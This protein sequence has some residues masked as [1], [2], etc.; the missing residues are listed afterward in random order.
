MH[1]TKYDITT[2]VSPSTMPKY[3]V[4][5]GWPSHFQIVLTAAWHWNRPLLI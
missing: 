3:Q 2:P 5:E 1:H 4:L